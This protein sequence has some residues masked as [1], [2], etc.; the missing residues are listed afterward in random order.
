MVAFILA[1][2]L[3]VLQPSKQARREGRRRPTFEIARRRM[4]MVMMRVRRR[5]ALGLPVCASLPM[6]PLSTVCPAHSGASS[7]CLYDHLRPALSQTRMSAAAADAS[8]LP[9]CVL[10][11]RCFLLRCC[12]LRLV[13]HIT[14][15]HPTPPAATG[16]LPSDNHSYTSGADGRGRARRGQDG[17]AM[18]SRKPRPHFFLIP[19]RPAP[20]RA[21]LL[22]RVRP[23]RDLPL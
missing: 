9:S 14:P 22:E 5:M 4:M 17:C 20:L 11:S 6:P 2:V 1:L 12:V 18:V 7:A 16:L 10:G 15:L 8:S 3:V 23:G 21:T 13:P 19:P